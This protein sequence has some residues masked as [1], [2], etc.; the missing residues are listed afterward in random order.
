MNYGKWSVFTEEKRNAVRVINNYVQ[1]DVNLPEQQLAIAVLEQAIKDIGIKKR[2]N[3]STMDWESGNLNNY[4]SMLGIDI[5][6]MYD[7]LFFFKLLDRDRCQY[8]I[9][10]QHRILQHNLNLHV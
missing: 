1:I 3:D 7:M 6:A 2:E 4:A 10:K 8:A 5:E 9:Y